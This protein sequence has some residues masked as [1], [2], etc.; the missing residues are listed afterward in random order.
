MVTSTK[1]PKSRLQAL[2]SKFSISHF[3]AF[4][5]LISG[6]VA[7]WDTTVLQLL[8]S[9]FFFSV[10][11]LHFC[12]VQSLILSSVIR[13]LEE[14][15]ILEK[16]AKTVAKQKMPKISSTVVIRKSKTSTSNHFWNQR[17]HITNHVL[18]QRFWAKNIF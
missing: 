15:Q 8:T 11:S 18:K 9:S 7:Y 3:P 13:R 16:V 6:L 10:F 2:P 14:G 5:P 17:K 4:E 1:M 12:N